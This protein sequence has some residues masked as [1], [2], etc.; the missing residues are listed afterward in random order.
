M[1]TITYD[2]NAF[3]LTKLTDTELVIL[4]KELSAE[5]SRRAEENENRRRGWVNIYCYNYLND[6]NASSVLV[7]ETTI[8]AI[9]DKKFGM[10][11]GKATP[12]HGDV[13]NRN[14]GIAVA[15][16]KAK[17]EKIPDFI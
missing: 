6:P 1:K 11:I 3:S 14:T 5:Q 9:Y 16:A 13:F 17:N 7:G 8:V 10:R 2:H 12:V 15:Y 4:A